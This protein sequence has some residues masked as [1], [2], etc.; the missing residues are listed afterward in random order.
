MIAAHSDW[1]VD[2]RKRWIT[3][4]RKMR[5]FWVLDAP[6][7]TGDVSQLVGRLAKAA[8]EQA[9]IL[10]IDCPIGLPRAYAEQ[11]AGFSDFPAFLK[12]LRRD[13]A[14]FEVAEMIDEVSLARPFFPKRSVVGPGFKLA[15]AAKLNLTGVAAM[16][17]VVDRRTAN[18]PAAGQMFWT[19][20]A[21][22][23]GKAAL[24]AWR[25]LLMPAFAAAQ[26]R[27]WP[28]DGDL[29][30]LAMPGQVVVAE[31]YPAEALRQVGLRLTGSKRDRTDRQS[32]QI[33]IR[34]V[35]DR[36]DIKPSDDLIGAVDDGFGSKP[37]GEDAFDS[38]IGALGVI[39]VLNGNRPDAPPGPVDM[40]EGWVLGQTD[41]PVS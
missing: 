3:I 29:R 30:S 5:D 24:A 19:L 11:I 12:S 26:I 37:A 8:N 2:K 32:L 4:G 22:Q 28:F 34:R 21:N 31:T 17:R 18:R 23:C 20:G 15:L 40:W 27:L 39:N 9:V 36:L 33:D 41:L 13:D 38:L 6:Q 7:P 14:F 35:M 25:D 10:G 16:S 1:S